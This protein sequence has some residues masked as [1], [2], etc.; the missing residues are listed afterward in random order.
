METGMSEMEV[1]M[2]LAAIKLA[3]EGNA[4]A[5]NHLRIENEI[6]AEQNR[7]S[8]EEELQMIAEEQEMMANMKEIYRRK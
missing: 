8:V 5:E 7:P 6:R 3:R 1:L 4:E 2:W